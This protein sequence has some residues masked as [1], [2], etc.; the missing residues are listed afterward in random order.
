MIQVMHQLKSH[1]DI[2]CYK[3]VR[4]KGIL[5]L[6]D[7]LGK[8]SFEAIGKGLRYK[9]VNHIIEAYGLKFN[10]HLMV[11]CFWNNGYVGFIKLCYRHTTITDIQHQISDIITH[12]TLMFLIKNSRQTIW[13][14]SL[15]GMGLFECYNNLFPGEI[16]G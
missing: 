5:V 4:G 15:C 2:I 3:L 1:K 6:Y 14:G 7:D 16:L 12:N 13:S 9:L 11:T 10:H 8:E